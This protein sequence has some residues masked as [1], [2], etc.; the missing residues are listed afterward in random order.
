MASLCQEPLIERF[1]S[2]IGRMGIF[3]LLLDTDNDLTLN[4]LR[5]LFH[6]N[7]HGD[8]VMRQIAEKLEVSDPTAT[9]VIDR[10]VERSLVERSSDPEDRRRVRV[11]L[12]A[13]G[14]QLVSE[15]RRSG[16]RSATAVFDQLA[17]DQKDALFQALAP[18]FELLDPNR[19]GN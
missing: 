14:C 19:A 1:F 15:M 10:L 12:S 6:L 16:A 9:G 13:R 4:Q 3:S 18:V 5:V 8:R 17:E 2:I 11:S 7:Y